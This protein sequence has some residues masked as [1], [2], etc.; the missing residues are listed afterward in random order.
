MFTPTRPLL[1]LLFGFVL[2]CTH[3]DS[4]QDPLGDG[5]APALTGDAQLTDAGLAD[6]LA[7]DAAG[8][9]LPRPWA[10]PDET[11]PFGVGL[12]T[13]Q[14]VDPRGKALVADVWY[15]AR[16]S[17]TDR[18]ARYQYTQI[19][20]IAHDEPALERAYGPHPLVAFS[21]G[22]ISLRFQSYVMMEHLA[23][24]G[25]VVVATDHPTNT[26]WD[27]D[28]DNDPLMMLE[29]P[30]DIR[31]SID[32]VFA[33]AQAPGLLEGAVATDQYAAVGHS[34]GSVTA[35]VLG[36]ATV[37]FGGLQRSCDAGI[38][39]GRVC[40]LVDEARALDDGRH[41]GPDPRVV[42]TVPM[43]PGIWYAFGPDGRGLAPVINPLVLAGT[44]DAVLA[45]EKEG[46]PVWHALTPPK[47][48][49]KFTQAGHYGFS[50][51]CDIL[52]GLQEECAG[53]DGGWEDLRWVLERSQTLV[54]AHLG[55][56]M[57][58]DP[59]YAPWLAA[60]EMT[61]EGRLV[62]ERAP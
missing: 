14:F 11:G 39:N 16:L 10:P 48:L 21:H 1:L 44:R 55:L 23:S 47:I 50:V 32:H 20:G 37:D 61:D 30:D 57:R 22:Y 33:L 2:G 8:E 54:V 40:A 6:G 36:G 28:P 43:S 4:G 15:P 12:T 24:H 56:I 13:L 18:I 31:Y 29:R 25:F 49:G 41:G 34:F 17:E 51:L 26:I 46:A 3:A 38:G 5:A 52:P 58:G 42:A 27:L 35:L 19:S 53:P 9:P 7:Q 60:N 59:R 45:W 62:V